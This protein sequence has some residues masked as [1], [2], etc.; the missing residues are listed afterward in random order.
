M[1]GNQEHDDEVKSIDV[2]VGYKLIA[3]GDSQGLIKI[4]NYRR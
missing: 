3:S 2:H 1:N 4:W